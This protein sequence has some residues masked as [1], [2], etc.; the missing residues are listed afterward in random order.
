[1]LTVR[2]TPRGGRDGVDGVDVLSDG[3]EV[4]KVRVR[5]VPEDGEAN[6]AV[7]KL[8]AAALK[9]RRGDIALASGATARLKQFELRGDAAQLTAALTGLVEPGA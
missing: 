5:A 4:L 7:I 2:V 9:I 8:I 3:R 6:A 1:M